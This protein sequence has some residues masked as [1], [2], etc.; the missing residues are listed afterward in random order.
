MN[1][2]NYI[3]EKNK[4]V[5]VIF[6]SGN[7]EFLESVK[8]LKQKDPNIDHLS[9]PCKNIDYVQCINRLMYNAMN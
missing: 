9:K 6:I 8:D 5:P 2:Y 7:I 1:I 3:R 4:T